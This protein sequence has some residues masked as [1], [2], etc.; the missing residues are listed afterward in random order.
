MHDRPRSRSATAPPLHQ[1]L[2]PPRDRRQD[3]EPLERRIRRTARWSGTAFG[4]AW[5]AVLAGFLL[6]MGRVPWLEALW[7]STVAGLVMGRTMVAVVDR[8][9]GWLLEVRTLEVGP[10]DPPAFRRA[11]RRRMARLGYTCRSPNLH[12][13]LFEA[14]RARLRPPLR[15]AWSG[16]G[17][18]LEG[19]RFVLR[20]AGRLAVG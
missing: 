17:A 15:V 6:G 14:P 3:P 18:V 19:P 5:A 20:S 2:R 13:D 12:T 1:A 11:L 8:F 4:C 10:M 7:W 16:P 9:L